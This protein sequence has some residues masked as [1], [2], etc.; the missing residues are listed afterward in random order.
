MSVTITFA[1]GHQLTLESAGGAA[2]VCE[3]CGESRVQAVKAPKPKFHGFCTGPCVE[4]VN[5]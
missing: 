1:C 4:T 3:Q 5:G 2:P